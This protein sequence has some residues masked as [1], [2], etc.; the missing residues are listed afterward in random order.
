VEVGRFQEAYD[1]AGKALAFDE[2]LTTDM[3]FMCATAKSQASIGRVGGAQGTLTNL[4]PK[5]PE[6]ESHPHFKAAV[7]FVKEQSMS[8]KH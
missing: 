7:E 5:K 6:V 2:R 3:Y 8:A 1:L 4:A